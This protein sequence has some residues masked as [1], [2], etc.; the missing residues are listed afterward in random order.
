VPAVLKVTP[1]LVAP[2]PMAPVL[3]AAVSDVAVCGRPVP[4]IQVTVVPVGTVMGFGL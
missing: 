1:P 3:Q 4:F 2:A